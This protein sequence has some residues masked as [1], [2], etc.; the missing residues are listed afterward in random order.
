[1]TQNVINVLDTMLLWIDEIPPL[2]TP[3]RF[4]NKA[5]RT[6][7]T[8]LEEVNNKRTTSIILKKIDLTRV[9]FT[10]HRKQLN[11][12]KIFCQNIY[13]KVLLNLSHILMEDLEML[14][15]SIMEVDMN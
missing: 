8:R 6:W 3:Q 5:F 4:G 7:M 1:M 13:M 10:Y 9:M 15:E 2:P 11:Y 14:Q 12:I